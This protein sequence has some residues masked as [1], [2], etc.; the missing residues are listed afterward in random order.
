MKQLSDLA[1]DRLVNGC[2]YCGGMS[3][4]RDHVPSLIFLDPPYP[5]NLPVVG[6]CQQCNQGFSMDEQYLVCLLGSVLAGSTDPNKI[7]RQSVARAMKRS[8][9][10]RSRIESNKRNIPGRI[11]FKAED[12]RVKNVMLKLARGHAAFELSQI[13][14][15]DPDHFWCGPLETLSAEARESFDAVHFQQFLGEIG[16]RNIQRMFVIQ[17]KPHA[18]INEKSGLGMLVNDWVEVQEG[19][20]R[21]L[22]IDDLGIIVIRIVIAEYMACEVGWNTRGMG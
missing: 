18:V 3:E 1:D 22:A 11:V 12:N 7:K 21:Y 14:R 10:L 8:P 4:T 6:A 13:R 5:E 2:I 19:C 17:L 20:Y 15:Q 9:A 16:S